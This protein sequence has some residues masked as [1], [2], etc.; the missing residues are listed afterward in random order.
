[1][2]KANSNGNDGQHGND[3]RHESHSSH[4]SHTVAAG[5]R[6]LFFCFVSV[7]EVA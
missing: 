6:P 4:Q 5:T 3:E 2:K 1:M 7:C